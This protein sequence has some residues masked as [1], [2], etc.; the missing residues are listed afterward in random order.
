MTTIFEK[1]TLTGAARQAL[2]AQ[3]MVAPQV[4]TTGALKHFIGVEGLSGEQI[5]QLIYKAD[6]Y[7]QDGKIVHTKELAGRTVVNLFFENSTRTRTTFELA[8]R[9]LGADVVSLDIAKSSTSKGESLSDTLWNLEAMSADAFVVRHNVSGAAHF[10]AKAVVPNVAVI[11]AGDGWHAHPTQ[12]MLDML[13]IYRECPRPFE[14]LSVAIIGDIKHSRVARSDIAA[15]QCLGV[16]DI[17]VIAP[18]T[19]LPSAMTDYNVQVYNDIE[20]GLRDVDVIIG[21]RIQNERIGSPLLPSVQEYFKAYGLTKDRVALAKTD[22]LV[23]HPGPINRGVEI[24]SE[25]ADGVQSVIL[26][27]VNNGIA[28][29]MAILAET[30][31][32]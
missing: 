8:A 32:R 17:R 5:M 30:I 20:Q 29:R 4:L 26:K 2:L 21:L 3:A 19:L 23:M 9:H 15:L 13:T 6:S 22:A 16:P 18:K 24:A 31:A 27:Q 14:R 10:I 11:N 12:A 28:V 25:V 7:I 1:Q